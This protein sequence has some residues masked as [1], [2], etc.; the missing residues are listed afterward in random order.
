MKT[1]KADTTESTGNRPPILSLLP[2]MP[3]S[4]S[5][6]QG[7]EAQ[8][9]HPFPLGETVELPVAIKGYPC[10]PG[11]IPPLMVETGEYILRFARDSYDL[12]NVCKL[13]FEVYNL[14]MDEGLEDSYRTHRDVDEFDAQCHHLIVVHRSSGALAGTY[15]IQTGPMA[16]LRGGFYSA[17]E[18]DLSGFPRDFIDRCVEVG[19]AC[20]GR[21][22]RNGRVLQL[23]WKGLARYLDWNGKRYLFGCCSLTSQDPAEG[24]ALYR[25]LLA[26]DSL[27]PT[28]NA[29]PKPE[30]SC[31]AGMLEILDTP[32]PRLPRLFE[33]YLNLGGLVCGEPA[34][35]RKFKT[36]DYLV[37]VDTQE[38]PQGVYRKMLA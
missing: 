20:I 6:E 36:I 16:M 37:V 17:Q 14:E 22:H 24:R 3:V 1:M 29:I 11:G 23:L 18:F 27:H 38:M 4:R 26:L 12:D 9:A 7:T 34:L 33:G 28:L 25:R 15:R 31:E 10:N 5:G 8:M 21:E 30:Y 35:D 32:Q 13:R 2:E 19:R